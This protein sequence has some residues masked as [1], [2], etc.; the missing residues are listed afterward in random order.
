MKDSKYLLTVKGSKAIHTA[1]IGLD[2]ITVLSGVNA[3]GKS[4][5]ARIL[6]QIVNLS[7]MYPVLLERHAWKPVKTWASQIVQLKNRLDGN[8]LVTLSAL[9]MQVQATEFERELEKGCFREVLG[10]LGAYS[11][12]QIS[13]CQARMAEGDVKRAYMAFVRAVGIGEE[14][15]GDP[16]KVYAIFSEKRQKCIETYEQLM[17]V[18]NYGVYNCATDM[19]FD[20][21]WLVDADEVSLCEDG[22]PV[23][24]VHRV[25]PSGT[26]EPDCPLKEIFGIRHS[27]YIASPWVSLPVISEDG[28]LQ[29]K[30][31]DFPHHPVSGVV[32]EGADMFAALGGKLTFDVSTGRRRWLFQRGDEPAVDLTDCATGIKSLSILNILYTQG[33]LNGETLV[34]V[35]EPEAHLH[36]QLIFDYARILVLIAKKFNVR[37]LL[38]SHNPDMVSAIKVVSEA[39]NLNGVQFYLANESNDAG[40]KFRYDYEPLGMNIEK[41]FRR[42]NVA[43]DRIDTYGG[44]SALTDIDDDFE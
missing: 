25:A 26:L 1:K 35:D 31:D 2:S 27:F 37:M 41:I 13:R 21:S 11:Q 23:Y 28:M 20:L 44:K 16:Q 34:I 17:H 39:E 40:M 33:Y 10:R 5:L 30:Y 7:S 29:M 14:L 15:T 3:C 36:P 38:T 18:R 43:L 6:H 22:E 12:E 19:K 4:T 24:A 42:F 32:A 8:G 9:G